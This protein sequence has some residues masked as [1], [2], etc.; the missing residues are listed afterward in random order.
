MDNLFKAELKR[1]KMSLI[2]PLLLLLLLTGTEAYGNNGA[3]GNNNKHDGFLDLFVMRLEEYKPVYFALS[4]TDSQNNAPFLSLPT[5]SR[6]TDSEEINFQLSFKSVLA[7]KKFGK[8]EDKTIYG[9][10]GYTQQSYWEVFNKRYSRPFRETNY[11]PELAVSYKDSCRLIDIGLGFGGCTY[12]IGVVHQS[13]GQYENLTRSWNRLYLSIVLKRENLVLSLKPWIR[14]PEE[15]G[16]ENPGI[17]KYL[18]R[19]EAMIHI[20]GAT[21]VPEGWFREKIGTNIDY[22]LGLIARNN[23]ST[24]KNR[25]SYQAD[26]T[27]Q[28]DGGWNV[29]IQYFNGYG[30][31][32]IDYDHSHSRLSVGFMLRGWDLWEGKS[33]AF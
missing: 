24:E 1:S 20:K 25:G 17:E 28:I 21:M 13:N 19:G 4:K 2:P 7:E 10:F 15:D 12:A 26:L 27:F 29:Y 6:V 11:E 18:G 33:Y 16:D 3:G 9:W 22:T 8:A 30:E 14:L 31:S 23:L 32:M 5:D